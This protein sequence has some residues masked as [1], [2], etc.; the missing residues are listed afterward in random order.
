MAR[1]YFEAATAAKHICQGGLL[2]GQ[3]CVPAGQKEELNRELQPEMGQTVFQ[4]TEPSSLLSCCGIL[5]LT[6]KASCPTPP[7]ATPVPLSL[8]QQGKSQHPLPA[9]AWVYAASRVRSEERRLSALRS[10]PTPLAKAGQAST[11]P[12][13][14][15]FAGR[16]PPHSAPGSS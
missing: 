4:N 10:L 5:A 14:Q 11:A 7:T 2:L 3:H 12:A 16:F 8:P 15:G 6:V 1:S 9:H 13:S